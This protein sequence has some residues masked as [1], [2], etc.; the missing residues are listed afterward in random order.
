VSTIWTKLD[1]EQLKALNARKAAFIDQH[2]RPLNSSVERFFYSNQI[3]GDTRAIAQA[4][5]DNA[6]QL[7]D[8][9]KPFDSGVRVE[10]RR[11]VG[12]PDC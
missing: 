9:L 11:I 1:E 2:L 6:D 4:F 3:R 7:R 12:T 5:I 10:E 8:L